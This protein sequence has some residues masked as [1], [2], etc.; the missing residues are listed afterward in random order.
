MKL[1]EA[2]YAAL[3]ADAG[4]I[5][6]VVDRIYPGRAPQGVALP[7]VVY[8]MVASVPD[9]THGETSQL[10]NTL[11]QFSCYAETYA[12]ARDLRQAVRATL[13]NQTLGNG[14]RPIIDTERDQFEE[15]ANLYHHL[16]DVNFYHDPAAAA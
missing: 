1:A 16:L 3:S 6:L 15:V 12:Q 8:F 10:D 9:Q 13:E 4:V 14:S 2:I 11:A 7:Y 5:A